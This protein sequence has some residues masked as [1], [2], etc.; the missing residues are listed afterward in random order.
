MSLPENNNKIIVDALNK[1]RDGNI[2]NFNIFY[3][4]KM[5]YIA[6]ILNLIFRL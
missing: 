1:K 3:N 2:T 6:N 5:I 4:A